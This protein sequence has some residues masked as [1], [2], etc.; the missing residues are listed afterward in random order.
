MKRVIITG[1]TGAIGMALIEYLNQRGIQ[2]IAVVRGD[3]GRKAQIR[4]SDNVAKVEC[5]LAEYDELP[6][7]IRNTILRKQWREDIGVDAFYHFAWEGT[8]GESRNDMY[9]QNR[10]V[11]HALEAV[12]AAAQ[13]G[14]KT[15]IG[16]GSQAEYGRFEGRLNAQVPVSPENGYGMA[17][18]CAGQMTRVQCEKYGIRHVWTRILSVYGPYDGMNTMIMSLLAHLA[19]G[20]EFPCTKGEQ[21]WDYLYSKDAAK[22]LYLLGEKGVHGKVYCLGSGTARTLK[23][24]VE[25]AKKLINPQSEIAYGAVDYAPKQ[26]MYLCADVR[27][28]VRDTGYMPDYSFEEGIRETAAWMGV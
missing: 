22:M 25:I 7:R 28:L 10:N 18:L 12:D 23:E 11:T 5:A 8:S 24:Y 21:M 4:E 26:V 20:N 15:F 17:K 2:V 1:P 27:E 16:A 6:I 13:I 14:C 3:S 19:E 9:L